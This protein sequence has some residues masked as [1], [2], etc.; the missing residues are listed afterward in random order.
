MS[1]FTTP[2][3][4]SGVYHI[5][6]SVVGSAI[7]IPV[8][9]LRPGGGYLDAYCGY[10]GSLAQNGLDFASLNV[11]P[12]ATNPVSIFSKGLNEFVGLTVQK[13]SHHTIGTHLVTGTSFKSY[14]GI[15]KWRGAANTITGGK[16][17]ISG[18]SLKIAAAET[19]IS[20]AMSVTMSGGKLTSIQ[21]GRV[22][23]KGRDWGI[24][25]KI[26][27][28]KKP[29]DI[30]HPTKEGQRL[31]YV[32]LEGPAAEVYVRGKLKNQNIIE[33]P[34]YWKGLVDANSISVSLTPVGTYQE[35]FVKKI[36]S[37][38]RIIIGNQGGSAINC[39][40]IVF[41][42]RK[43]T[44]KNIPEYEGLTPNDYPGDNDEYRL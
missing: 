2:I 42:E 37:A 19:H 17:T 10:F 14:A 8:D 34:D 43:D 11:G 18:K 24:S 15:N 20:S 4:A 32:S 36:E 30:L 7:Q 33:L 35:L 41:A 44:S 40:Y 22:L 21:G 39:D 5:I 6:N 3:G 38:N 28:S 1:G 13:G 16:T 12:G 23:I 25:S 29:F 26:W 27:D 9:M 31:R